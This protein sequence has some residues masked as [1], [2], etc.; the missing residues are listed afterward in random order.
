MRAQR[1][2]G[3]SFIELIATL[4]IIGVLLLIVMPS[5]QTVVKRH[6]EAELRLAL[7]QIR[8]AI[9]HYKKAVETGRIA[10]ES[11][12]SGYPPNLE[13]LSEGVVDVSSPSEA[14]IYFLRRLPAD[15]F[16]PGTKKSSAETWGLRSYE[17][18]PDAPEAGEDV[19]D[20]YSTSTGVGLNGIAY[21]EW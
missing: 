13:V 12:S 7:A 15:P 8:G 19:F 3:F 11:G 18:P 5:A 2:A 16:H 6:R 21:R 17:S 14:K 10:V 1:S 20:V 9:D 4:A